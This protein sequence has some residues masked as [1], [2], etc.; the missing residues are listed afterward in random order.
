MSNGDCDC[1]CSFLADGPR[2]H[3][4]LSLSMLNTDNNSSV[5]ALNCTVVGRNEV[6]RPDLE[7]DCQ[8][9]DASKVSTQL[10][11]IIIIISVE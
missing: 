2:V 6:S 4:L 10:C 3:E 11:D 8:G 7:Q 1:D 9:G 5:D